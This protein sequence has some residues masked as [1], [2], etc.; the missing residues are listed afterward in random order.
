MAVTTSCGHMTFSTTRAQR[1]KNPPVPPQSTQ[2]QSEFAKLSYAY[3]ASPMIGTEG[4]TDNSGTYTPS[5]VAT[6]RSKILRNDV[7]GFTDEDDDSL[8]PVD[9]QE[10]Q[11]YWGYP[12]AKTSEEM[13]S[14]VDLMYGGAP[15]FK[16]MTTFKDPIPGAPDAVI[17]SRYMPNLLPPMDGDQVNFS[18]VS[19]NPTPVVLNVPDNINTI[20][21]LPPG[22][23]LGHA[24]NPSMTSKE[25]KGIIAELIDPTE[26]QLTTPVLNT[27][28][29]GQ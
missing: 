8:G 20:I 2:A 10:S 13:P 17:A 22:Q 29:F 6:L 1:P 23:G 19:D 3:P 11:T 26:E 28:V 21:S 24:T 14:G 12:T 15:N 18:P 25:V 5:V 4:I 16:N 9:Q 27:P 7:K